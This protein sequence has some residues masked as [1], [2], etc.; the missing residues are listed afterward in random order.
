MLYIIYEKWNE[1]ISFCIPTDYK[2]PCQH[3]LFYLLLVHIIKHIPHFKPDKILQVSAIEKVNKYVPYLTKNNVLAFE[4]FCST[5]VLN[6][7][8]FFCIRSLISK[9]RMAEV[10][11]NIRSNWPWPK[12]RQTG[13]DLVLLDSEIWQVG[14]SVLLCFCRRWWKCPL[15]WK[16]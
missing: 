7:H 4:M 1:S 16:T 5:L 14:T 6:K 10:N 13:K 15:I 9:V 11:M 2:G 12:M 8:V 3:L